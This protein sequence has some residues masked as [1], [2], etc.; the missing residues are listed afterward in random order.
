MT[1]QDLI[2]LAMK[3]TTALGIGQT[4]S[5]EDLEDGFTLLKMMLAQW[6]RNRY[7]VYR[8]RTVSI[9]CDGRQAYTIGAGG[10][11]DTA[12]PNK[13]ESAFVRQ[14]V[15]GPDPVDYD[16]DILRAREDYNRISQKSLKSFPYCLFY[17]SAY[18]L[19]NVYPWPV[20]GSQFQLHL[21]VMEPLQRFA[22]PYD[23]FEMPDEYQE[24]IMYNLAG[25]LCPLYGLSVSA[26]LAG[27]ARASL[28]I[29]KKANAQIPRL[30]VPG[31]LIRPGAYN[32]YADQSR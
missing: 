22:T 1:P 2:I 31:E 21:T 26:E 15:P 14:L 12:R 27:L 6:Q 11:I 24:A 30:Q 28:N 29:V 5:A 32:V 3:Q 4:A 18:P 9:T 23:E 13:I 10:D 19:G 20:P 25:R 7:N 17:D 8:L 16:L